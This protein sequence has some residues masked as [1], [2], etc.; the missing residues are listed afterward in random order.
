MG[1]ICQSVCEDS[2]TRRNSV[3]GCG[4][5]GTFTEIRS[6]VT[7]QLPSLRKPRRIAQCPLRRCVLKIRAVRPIYKS[8]KRHGKGRIEKSK[9]KRKIGKYTDGFGV[10]R[11]YS[12]PLLSYRLSPVV[13]L[14]V[15]VSVIIFLDLVRIRQKRVLHLG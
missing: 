9:E 15:R 13:V 2:K 6:K 8:G 4:S 12:S 11:L 3:I 5:G 1:Q 14:E 7:A 10:S